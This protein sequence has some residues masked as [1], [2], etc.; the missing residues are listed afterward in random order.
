[1]RFTLI[2]HSTLLV[3]TSGPRIVVDPWLLG[4][5]YWRAW[6]HFPPSSEP[7]AE[8]LAPDYVYVTH[9]HFDHLHYPS[10]RRIDRRAHVLV[11]TLA[12][13][14]RVA[15]YQY[16]FDDTVFVIAD[17]EHVL[18][19][20]NDCKM[21]GR[22]LQQVVRDFPEPTFMFKSHSWA[23]SYP[24]CYEADD[25]RDLEVL[26]RET[27]LDDFLGVAR[28]LR[29]RHAVPFGSMVAFLHPDTRHLNRHLV[30]PAEVR[31]AACVAGDDVPVVVMT[32]GDSWDS[33]RG[34]SIASNDWYE[35]RDEHLAQLGDDLEP[36]M[37]EL[38]AAEA[39]RRTDFATFARYLERFARALPTAVARRLLPR[40][41]VFEVP[42]AAARYWT[43]DFVARSVT[44]R[45]SVPPNAATVICI[46]EAV[47][48]DAIDKGILHLVHGSMRIR[49]RLRPGGVDEDLA[50]WGLLMIWEIGYLPIARLLRPRFAG[51]LWRR[52]REA[53][54]AIDT[55]RGDG[56]LLGRLAGRFSPSDDAP[57]APDAD[58]PSLPDADRAAAPR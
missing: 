12:P 40:P 34:F 35:R 55:L 10:M 14:V 41:T 17:G 27:Y 6:W 5:C 44:P 1:M 33:E 4:S 37:C 58:A 9:H 18:V 52:R 57:A 39:T 49:T 16:G 20:V 24:N 28:E 32:P 31:D 46:P 22:A 50:F 56:S 54:D 26:S 21:R 38:A 8:L 25:P 13:D 53:L 48:A 42:S 19:D 30:T 47:L 2:G 7:T 51:V 43:V 23:Q 29:P 36:L 3:E 11:V 45:R 15:S